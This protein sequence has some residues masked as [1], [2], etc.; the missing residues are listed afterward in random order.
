MCATL[1]PVQRRVDLN[2]DLGESYGSWGLGDDDEMLGVVTS[3]NIA[4]GFH[5]GDPLTMRRTVVGAVRHGVVVGAHVSYPDLVGFGRRAMDLSGPELAADVLAQ[6]GALDAMCRVEG[7][8]V[9][10]LKCHG[11]LYHRT[12]ADEAQATVVAEAVAAYDGRLAVL[13]MADGRLAERAA[14]IGLRVVAE[15]YA[16]RAYRADGR[17]VPRGE[18]GAVLG[19]AEEAAGQAVTLVTS[20]RFG[21]ICL[22]GDTPGAVAMAL[23]VRSGLDAAGFK[24]RPFA[25]DA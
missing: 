17:L 22:H 10:Y 19:T 15:G 7:T 8:R 23:A 13:T 14:A 9:R 12:V 4:C 11:A 1:S 18:P 16:D 2:A 3:A 20:G 6:L 24:L 5:A 21:S 25:D